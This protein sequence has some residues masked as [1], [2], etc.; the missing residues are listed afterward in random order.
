VLVV[1][2]HLSGINSS[3]QRK[4]DFRVPV[5]TGRFLGGFDLQSRKLTAILTAKPVDDSHRGGRGW[6]ARAR[7][8]EDSRRSRRR[9]TS[10]LRIRN[11]LV[12][13][14][15]PSNG[16]K[17]PEI[18]ANAERLF[19]CAPGEGNIDSSGEHHYAQIRRLAPFNSRL[20]YPRRQEPE[21]YK[22]PHGS[23]IETLSPRDLVNRL[24]TA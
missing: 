10:H 17:R 5:G 6:K 21:R 23:A 3:V 24:W 9:R 8:V 1:S 22:A 12:F 4:L 18:L 7:F 11:Q 20:D 13:G 14:P 2:P 19:L 15:N 16:L